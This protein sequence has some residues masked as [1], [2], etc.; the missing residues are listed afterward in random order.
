[1][2]DR[3]TYINGKEGMPRVCRVLGLGLRVWSLGIRV[4]GSWPRLEAVRLNKNWLSGNS[5]QFC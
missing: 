2:W 3:S 1:M 4:Y 5:A